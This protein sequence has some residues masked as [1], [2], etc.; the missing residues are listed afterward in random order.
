[1][2][3]GDQGRWA[4]SIA[5]HGLLGGLA[6]HA[7]RAFETFRPPVMAIEA[8]VLPEERLGLAGADRKPLAAA[9]ADPGKA[10]ARH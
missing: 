3:G 5:D 1:M 10:R 8:P 7:E 4:R 2:G 9:P 6:I